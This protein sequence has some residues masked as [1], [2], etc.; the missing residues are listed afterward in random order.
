MKVMRVIAK[1]IDPE[2]YGENSDMRIFVEPS[3]D[4]I[5]P[6]LRIV[7]GIPKDKRAVIERLYKEKVIEKKEYEHRVK[8]PNGCIYVGVDTR[9]LGGM[10]V[11]PLSFMN[12]CPYR[13]MKFIDRDYEV[14]DAAYE[15]IQML[16]SQAEEAC[17]EEKA[18]IRKQIEEKGFEAVL[19][20]HLD[21]EYA[22]MV[23]FYESRNEME[24]CE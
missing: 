14:P 7:R 4:D 20:E 5:S 19:Q 24:R 23:D 13:V 6:E 1:T 22:R 3:E 2:S 8:V 9:G 11:N 21:A 12:H 15:K 10:I 17:A 18:V 16:I